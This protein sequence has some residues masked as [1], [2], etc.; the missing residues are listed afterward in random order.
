MMIDN[1][2]R[3]KANVALDI[4][5]VRGLT[6]T[7][8][9]KY[10]NDDYG[11]NP[12]TQEGLSNSSS[13][14]A[15]VDVTYL[16][17]PDTSFMVGYMNEHYHQLLYGLSSTSNTA[18][19]GVGGVY[20]ANTG[21]SS[22]VHTLT[23]AVRWAAIPSKLDLGLRYSASYGTDAER[24]NLATAANNGNP[25][26]PATMAPQTNCQFPDVTTWFQ[27]LDATAVYTFDQDLVRRAGLTG[28]VR[29]KL[30]Y[31]WER[32]SVVNW[33]NDPLAPYSPI[34]STQGIWLASDNPNYNAHML[35]ASLSYTW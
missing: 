9:F 11:V 8:T 30:R 7:P 27:R 28:Q 20:S 12:L 29:A 22:T 3:T 16:F 26:C 31:T 21:D 4:T 2:Q 14:S 13:T 1:R 32:N 33:Q 10:Q 34:V 25:T 17:N 18:V 15:G 19:L 35:A 23:A 6:V 5:V 24:L